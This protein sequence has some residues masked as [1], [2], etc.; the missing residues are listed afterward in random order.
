MDVVLAA[1]GRTTGGWDRLWLASTI[2][3]TTIALTV[4]PHLFVVGFGIPPLIV[5]AGCGAV[6]IYWL[7]VAFPRRWK[8]QVARHGHDKAYSAAFPSDI[9][10]GICSNFAQLLRPFFYGF[11][12]SIPPLALSPRLLAAG[13]AVLA[14]AT[15]IFLA[16]R[17]IGI[18]G[19]MF[20]REYSMTEPPLTTRGI[21][22]IVRHPLYLGG[23][24]TSVGLALI[25]PSAAP[26]TLAACNC[27]V[28]PFYLLAERRRALIVFGERYL[29]YESQVRALVPFPA[30]ISQLQSKP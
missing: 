12:T 3:G 30:K 2:A 4:I 18:S 10:L 11:L 1:L 7:G 13:I 22:G 14:G 16:L 28:A 21:Y 9:R 19:A 6:W 5:H 27:V 26:V 8:A 15:A 20:V 29:E 25:F 23:L 24:V 17:V